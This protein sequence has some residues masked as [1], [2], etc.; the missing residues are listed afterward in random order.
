MEINV[1]DTNRRKN[2]HKSAIDAGIGKPD[3]SKA[4]M[5]KDMRPFPVPEN[6]T[7]EERIAYATHLTASMFQREN[8][9]E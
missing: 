3:L 5:E 4:S 8:E 6:L 2:T 7:R 9:T 1:P